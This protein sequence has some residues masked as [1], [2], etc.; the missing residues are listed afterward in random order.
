M[1]SKSDQGLKL[2]Y[3]KSLFCKETIE[4]RTLQNT[5]IG[6]IKQNKNSEF[7]AQNI[8]NNFVEVCTYNDAQQYIL[9]SYMKLGKPE[10]SQDSW[11][12]ALF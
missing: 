11:Q 1:P 4:I 2:S 7:V 12:L 9:N 8:Q 5:L 10:Y 3:S 6:T